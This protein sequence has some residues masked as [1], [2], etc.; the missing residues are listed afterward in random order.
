MAMR[1]PRPELADALAQGLHNIGQAAALTGVSAKMIRHYEAIGLLTPATRTF[2]NYRVYGEAEL[3]RLRFIKRARSLG[4]S[5][6][7]IEAL[8]ALWDDPH[9]A[10]A[11]VKQLALAH[12]AE[13]EEKIRELQAMQ[14]TLETLAQR[15]HGDGRPTCPILEDLAATQ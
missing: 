14:R 10:S 7:Q 15:C 3:H 9:R 12:V 8:L 5:I 1:I 2:A 6:R 11:E 4:F 13:L